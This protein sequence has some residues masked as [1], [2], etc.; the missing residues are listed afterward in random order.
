[1]EFLKWKTIKV[2]INNSNERSFFKMIVDTLSVLTP[3]FDTITNCL[4]LFSVLKM[5][6]AGGVSI[7][8]SLFLIYSSLCELVSELHFSFIF[9]C[10]IFRAIICILLFI[11]IKWKFPLRSSK[12]RDPP[13]LVFFMPAALII[14]LV[15]FINGSFS[16]YFHYCGILLDAF[17]LFC[18][19]MVTKQTRRILIF[20]PL[21]LCLLFI[22]QILKTVNLGIE[23]ILKTEIH[24]WISWVAS[25]ITLLSAIDFLFYFIIAHFKN[26]EYL[27]D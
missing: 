12:L 7:F 13:E 6:S 22:T 24:C 11:M 26:Q 19:M 2:F 15:C 14:S 18:Q 17:A 21:H 3:L 23:S 1:M 27:P 4:F 16:I 9:L 20:R 8:Y 5:R 25:V 10:H